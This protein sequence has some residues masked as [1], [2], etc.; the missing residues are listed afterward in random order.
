MQAGEDE[1]VYFV[2]RHNT[3]G[4]ARADKEAGKGARDTQASKG[5]GRLA[6]GGPSKA[7]DDGL[8]TCLLVARTRLERNGRN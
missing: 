7:L 1:Y 3:N 8:T 4:N 6:E 2:V 5:T